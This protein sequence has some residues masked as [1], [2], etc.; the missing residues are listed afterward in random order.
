LQLVSK[1]ESPDLRPVEQQ[2]AEFTKT[3]IPKNRVCLIYDSRMLLH[4]DPNDKLEKEF[5][6]YFFFSFSNSKIIFYFLFI[7]QK[8]FGKKRAHFIDIQRDGKSQPS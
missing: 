7:F 5:Y 1:I 6:F 8:P 3:V 2:T 4:M